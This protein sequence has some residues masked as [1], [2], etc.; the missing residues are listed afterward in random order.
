MPAWAIYQKTNLNTFDKCMCVHM[1]IHVH[2]GIGTCV[3]G[4]A[5]RHVSMKCEG[6][7]LSLGVCLNLDPLY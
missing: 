2:I 5:C 4:W 6:L 1:C 3:G 7:K